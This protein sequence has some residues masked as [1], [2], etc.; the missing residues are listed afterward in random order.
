MIMIKEHAKQIVNRLMH[1][2]GVKVVSRKWGPRG[3]EDTLRR[4]LAKGGCITHAVDIGAARGE[5][6]VQCMRVIPDAQ[7]LLIDPLQENQAHL[8]G[9]SCEHANVHYWSGALG[10]RAEQ[11]DMHVHGDQSSFLTSD[12]SESSIEGRRRIETK[13]LD[14]LLLESAF[15]PP[16]LIK[17]D[18]QGYELEVLR[19]AEQSL[20]SVDYVLLEVSFQQ[21]YEGGALA[22]E[23]INF[24]GARGFRIYDICSYAQRPLDGE[25]AQSDILFGKDTSVL[26]KVTVHRV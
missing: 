16:Q 17:A 26:F 19:G 12:F 15:G 1:P 5:W 18:V 6:T 3:Y 14:A 8:D 21:I 9:L 11:R 23:I 24:M 22:H 10:A 25:L 2:L 7:Y 20:H 4:I 13:T